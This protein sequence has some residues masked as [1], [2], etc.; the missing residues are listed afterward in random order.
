LEK[1]DN[2]IPARL[3]LGCGNDYKVGFWNVDCGDCKKD[4]HVNLNKPLS[5]PSNHFEYV[6]ACQVMEHITKEKFFDIFK[7]LHRILKPDGILDIRVPKA[8]SDNFWTDPTHTMPF[9]YRTMDFLIEGKPL[10]ENGK[11]YGADYSFIEDETVKEDGNE[12][13]YFKLRKGL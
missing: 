6:Y 1:C 11:I 9:T 3:N 2:I 8:G 10:R 5:L 4:Q 7:E 13:L 12:T